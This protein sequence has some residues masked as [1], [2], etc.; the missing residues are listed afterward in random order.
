[1]IK[2]IQL[3]L[4]KLYV[5]KKHRLAHVYGVRDTALELGKKYKL[6]LELLEKAALLHDIAKYYSHD[7][8]IAIIKKY[9]RN[10]EEILNEYN[11][12][13][14]HAFSAVYIAKEEFGITHPEILNSIMS[15][16]VGRP[17][18]SIYEKIIF[19]SDYIEPNRT[20][21]SCEKVRAI[22]KESLDKAVY[23]AIYDSVMFHERMNAVIPRT[24]YQA[25]EY[26]QRVVEEQDGKNSSIN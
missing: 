19:I 14:L 21:E 22:A 20:Y 11:P 26:Y 16:T 2:E 24:A 15:H 12:K 9:Y 18:M 8:N 25:R 13:I 4:E 6:D 5:N 3:K 10:S 17:E 1:M 7:E 23:T